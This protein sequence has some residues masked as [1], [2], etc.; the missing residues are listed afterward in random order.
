MDFPVVWMYVYATS[1]QAVCSSI[2]VEKEIREA[3]SDFII[4]FVIECYSKSS[5]SGII[6]MSENSWQWVWPSRQPVKKTDLSFYAH[7]AKSQICR[8]SLLLVS[9]G[10]DQSEQE[11]V[12]EKQ[13]KCNL[14][15]GER[16]GHSRLCPWPKQR[17]TP[18]Q[19]TCS[20]ALY[21]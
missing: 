5:I 8:L 13:H 6:W 16:T 10:R 19:R 9:Q 12:T 11:S 18:R 20:R 7:C 3:T 4:E 2:T 17:D 21:P 14:A 15:T 1:I